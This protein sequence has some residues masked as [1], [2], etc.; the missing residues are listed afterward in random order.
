MKSYGPYYV[1][2]RKPADGREWIDI[3]TM[4]GWRDDAIAKVRESD[5]AAGL[6]W[7]KANPVVRTL[8]VRVVEDLT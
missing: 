7:A 6:S 2:V 3:H 8:K 5:R 1:A 4:T